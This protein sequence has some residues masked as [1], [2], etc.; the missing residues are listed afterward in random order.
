MA[1]LALWYQTKLPKSLITELRK[2]TRELFVTPATVYE[3]G[4]P[5]VTNEDVRQSKVGWLSTDH[6]I[7]GFLWHYIT[8]ANNNNFHYDISHVDNES[9]QFTQYDVGEYYK[10]HCDWN[11]GDCYA[12]RAGTQNHD[13]DGRVNDFIEKNIEVCRKLSFSLQ[14]SDETAYDGGDLE[15]EEVNGDTF[16]APKERGTM[17]IF[18]SRLKHRVTPV[19]RGRRESLV[20]WIV[21]PRWK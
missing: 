16:S 11:L 12:P 9:M 14:M 2:E 8:K 15:F 3:D 20:G 5:D 18:D 10:W 13:T 6:W 17:I 21:G 7:G 1:N 4:N 19:T